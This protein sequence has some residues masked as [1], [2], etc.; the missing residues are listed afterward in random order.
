MQESQYVWVPV[1]TFI[2][3]DGTLSVEIKLGRYV[4]NVTDE[5]MKLEQSVENYS[6]EVMINI[7]YKELIN[8]QKGVESTEIGVAEN[9]TS[10]NLKNFIDSVKCKWILCRKI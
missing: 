6:S 7:F 4:F 3:D 5:T 8:Y 9:A 10:K 2:K 1:R